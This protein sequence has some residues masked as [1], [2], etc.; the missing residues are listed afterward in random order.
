[1]FDKQINVHDVVR[2]LIQLMVGVG[3]G[4]GWRGVMFHGSV[5]STV[6]KDSIL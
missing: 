3:W 4:G 2:A 1:M 5:L 6:K